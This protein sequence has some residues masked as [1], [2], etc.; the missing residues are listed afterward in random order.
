MTPIAIPALAPAEREGPGVGLDNGL[1]A[2]DVVAADG[3][4]TVDGAPVVLVVLV[5]LV[6][7][8]DALD[9][10]GFSLV[11]MPFTTKKPWPW[12]QHSRF[13]PP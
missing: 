11:C 7:L 13:V 9:E 4:E 3:S 10:F 6:T 8:D 5:V 1:V 2:G 12:A